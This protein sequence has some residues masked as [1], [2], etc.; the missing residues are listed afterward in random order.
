MKVILATGIYPPDIG[1]PATY[2]RNLAKQLTKK[3]VEVIVIAYQ[4]PEIPDSGY[5]IPDDSWPVIR[6]SKAGSPILRWLHYAKHVKKH[7]KD[8]D[9]VYAFSSISCAWPLLLAGLKKPIKILRLGGDFFW[10]RYTARGGAKSLR[11][12]YK[13]CTVLKR[14]MAWILKR[15][16][17]IVF[18]TA[19][20][21]E[22][23]V[24][25]YKNLPSHG[26]IENAIE[27]ESE[28]RPHL[29]HKPLRL[30]A[31]CRLVSFKNIANL[32]RA[33][34]EIDNALLTI[35]GDGPRKALLKTLV[36]QLHVDDRVVFTDPVHGEDKQAM[37]RESD[38]MVLPSIT[39]ISPNA[40]LE[41]RASGLPVLLTEQTG[42]SEELTKGMIV[43]PLITPEEIRTGIEEVR[44]HY[45]EFAVPAA[46]GLP[47]RT[48]KVVC[49]E[50]MDLFHSFENSKS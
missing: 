10:E 47:E 18:S 14:W 30:L 8:A 6:V 48:W 24:D 37:F 35:V 17:Y 4:Q 12:Y 20:Q 25:A 27:A 3:G 21:Q 19:F 40:A 22:I 5:Q 50:H 42:L 34:A 28:L 39:E 7:G 45:A 36:E 41:A 38:L 23:Y 1:G 16:D 26:V 29:I 9:I 15:M 43:R 33:M 49:E 13:C 11:D 46:T 2:V 31:M 32:I 44:E